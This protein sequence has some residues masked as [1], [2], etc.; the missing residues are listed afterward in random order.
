MKEKNKVS[1]NNTGFTLIETIIVMAILVIFASFT[2][3]YMG[4]LKSVNVRQAANQVY[5]SL[6]KLQVK[7]MSK[8]DIPH[9]YIYKTDNGCYMKI[10][11][12][13]ITAFDS[14]VFDDTGTKLGSAS[15]EIFQE[16]NGS[17]EEIKGDKFINIYYN[18]S[19]Q[20]Q[21]DVSAVIFKRNSEYKIKLVKE[22]GRHIME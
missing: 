21:S 9:L 2:F 22:T 19:A 6:D 5:T 20:F 12:S 1:N 13:D 18:K 4:H 17:K 11:T 8:T 15:I 3:L 7:T 14:S 10:L 16:K